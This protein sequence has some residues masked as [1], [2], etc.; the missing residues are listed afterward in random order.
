[1]LANS[2]RGEVSRDD[3]DSSPDDEDSDGCTLGTPGADW[4]S[5]ARGT[6]VKPVEL[7]GHTPPCRH[8]GAY[9]SHPCRRD[10]SPFAVAGQSALTSRRP[11]R[12]GGGAGH[13]LRFSTFLSAVYAP[14]HGG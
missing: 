14:A 9:H 2:Y 6:P 12:R 4:R 3:R 7:V 8:P 11:P 13:E 5:R 10:L 1:M